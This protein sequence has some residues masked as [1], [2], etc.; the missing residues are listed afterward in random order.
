MYQR[1]LAFLSHLAVTPPYLVVLVGRFKGH[2]RLRKAPERSAPASSERELVEVQ[3]G[4]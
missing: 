2:T 3:E 4:V 1:R